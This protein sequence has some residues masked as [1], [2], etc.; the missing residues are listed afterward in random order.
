MEL[1]IIEKEAP[2]TVENW[3]LD[4]FIKENENPV[5]K[6][7]DGLSAKKGNPDV[8]TVEVK[9]QTKI[10]STKTFVYKELEDPELNFEA[11]MFDSSHWK[12]K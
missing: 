8:E 2:L 4:D 5:S 7:K 11:W 10:Y 12:V 9:K 3:M 1:T 6:N